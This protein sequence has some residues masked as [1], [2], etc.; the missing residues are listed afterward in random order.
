MEALAIARFKI[1][2]C[3]WMT[4]LPDLML[5]EVSRYVVYYD[6]R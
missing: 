5:A 3:I 6:M 1:C 4:D 2:Q